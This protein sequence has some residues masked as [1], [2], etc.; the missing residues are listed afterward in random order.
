[1]HS[2]FDEAPNPKSKCA[3]KCTAEALG[4]YWACAGACI[5]K[6]APNACI[7]DGCPVAVT[8]FDVSCLKS[9]KENSIETAVQVRHATP[10][11]FHESPY[12]MAVSSLCELRNHFT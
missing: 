5:A 6:K 11:R 9:C 12:M 8:A 3:L 4:V 2:A 1:M 7:L 10:R